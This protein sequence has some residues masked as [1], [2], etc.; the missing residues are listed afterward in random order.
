MILWRYA[1]TNDKPANISYLTTDKTKKQSAIIPN[2]IPIRSA[3]FDVAELTILPTKTFSALTPSVSAT[4]ALTFASSSSANSLATW[5]TKHFL[6]NSA[7]SSP[8]EYLSSTKY[9]STV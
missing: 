6:V 1:K 7:F 5:T 9:E 3:L 2:A 4:S 8:A